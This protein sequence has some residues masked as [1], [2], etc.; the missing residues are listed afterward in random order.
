MNLGRT[1]STVNIASATYGVA[2]KAAMRLAGAFLKGATTRQS[3]I[4][5]K[6]P[7]QADERAYEAAAGLLVKGTPSL[8]GFLVMRADVTRRGLLDVKKLD[9]ALVVGRPLVILWPLGIKVPIHIV[10]A[11]DRIVDV[12]S[13][14]PFHLVSA[15]KQVEGRLLDIG[16]AR[17]LLEY[18]VTSVFA[19]MRTGRSTELVLKRLQAAHHAPDPLP[20]VPSLDEL[21]GYGEARDWGLALAEDIRA[22]ESAEIPWSDVDRGILISGPPGSGKTL[23]ASALARTCGIEVVATSVSRWQSTGHLGDMLGAMRT[24]FQEAAAKKP[25]ILFLDEL[26]SIGDRATFKGDN[27][28]YSN[29]VVNGL[30]EL[31]DGYDRLEGVVV[32]GAT[33]FPEKIDPALR[34]AGRLDR[35]IAISLPDAETRRS[36]CRRYIRKDMPEGEIETIVHATAGFSGADFEQIGR[37]IRRRARRGGAEI[38]AELALSV[39]PPTLKI[40]GER[41]RT[42]AVHEAGHAIVGIRVAV[43]R[44]DSIEVA[45]DVPRTGSAAG[46]AHFVLDGDV[47][48]DRQTLLSQIA[49]L[50]GGRLAEEVILGSAFEGSGGEGSDI[51]KATDLATVMEV[52]LGMGESLGYFRASSSADLEELRRRIPAVRERVEMVLLKQWKRARIIVEEHVGVIELVAS[53]LAAKG[54]L[55]GKEVEQMMSAKLRERSP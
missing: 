37:D 42:V 13:V 49:M 18:P 55:D 30:L 21:E 29:Q 5:L 26:D 1:T 7:P 38:T 36:L 33:N 4:I 8:L 45:R 40:E 16:E 35:H 22:W 6:L 50:L 23:F 2:L 53:Q 14:R 46:F 19:S 47:E 28:Q 25:C 3:V 9:D 24:S 17:R 15:A 41:R 34:R 48:R 31:V 11:A 52:Q 39:L 20:S 51:Q 54:R 43:G 44:L 32:V 10:A 27:A 12:R